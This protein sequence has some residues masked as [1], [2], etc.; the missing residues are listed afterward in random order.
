MCA[1]VSCAIRGG[2]WSLLYPHGGCSPMHSLKA[3]EEFVAALCRQIG[4]A[5]HSQ[6]AVL[7]GIST[8]LI[9]VGGKVQQGISKPHI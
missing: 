6:A 4:A 2:L 9:S 8:T 3:S 1:L 5:S 7:L